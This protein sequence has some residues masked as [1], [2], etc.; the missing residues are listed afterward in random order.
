MMQ[1]DLF[2]IHVFETPQK[3]LPYGDGP[4]ARPRILGEIFESL[5]EAQFKVGGTWH[6][7]NSERIPDTDTAFYMKVGRTQERVRE[8]FLDSAFRRVTIPEADTSHVFLNISS[9][10]LAVSG[11]P[12]LGSG[13]K[14]ANS[15]IRLLMASPRSVELE[16]VLK[17][18]AIPDPRDLIQH[19]RSAYSISKLWIEI[20]RKNAHNNKKILFDPVQEA[21]ERF[22][23]DKVR[24]E[25]IESQLARDDLTKDEIA[26][27][28]AEATTIG[29]RAGGRI[30]E[31]K[32]SRPRNVSTGK[33]A[34]KAQVE[35]VGP[36]TDR[37]EKRRRLESIEALVARA[38]QGKSG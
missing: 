11:N 35:D 15:F 20:P 37:S 25:F 1:F 17:V 5:P 36:E 38:R 21:A 12:R 16:A 33:A 14:I 28:I 2:R 8:V 31:G 22:H 3:P 9:E 10:L 23:F 32:K 19:I 26:E 6:I 4:D 24:L 29:G 27:L 34:L 30:K 18:D 13:E 7:A